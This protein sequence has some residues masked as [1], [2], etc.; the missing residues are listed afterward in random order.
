LRRFNYLEEH[1]LKKG[2]QLKEM[3]LEEMD[4]I[5]DEAKKLGL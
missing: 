1:T 2:I 4:V 5:W 3:S